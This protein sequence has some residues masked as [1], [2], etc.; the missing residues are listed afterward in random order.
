MLVGLVGCAPV[1]PAPSPERV[2]TGPG[3][4]P[5][6]STLADATP[7]PVSP[8]LRR[9]HTGQ[10]VPRVVVRNAFLRVQHVF[11]DWRPVGSVGVHSS[12]TFDVPVGTHT[13]TCTDSPELT[14]NP[15]SVTELFESGFTYSY[16]ILGQ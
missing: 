16:E 8:V 6:A 2:A 13:I 10:A 12:A 4:A 3:P 7:P 1:R 9:T 5:S 15:G 14:D 11:I